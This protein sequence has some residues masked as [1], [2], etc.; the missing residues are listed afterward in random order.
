MV[1]RPGGTRALRRRETGAVCGAHATRLIETTMILVKIIAIVIA[2]AAGLL[3]FGLEYRW[4][5][6][7]TNK[8]KKVKA[9]LI[10]LM[11]VGLLTASIL[12]VWDGQQSEEQIQSAEKAAK[13]SE[14]RELK[15]IEDRE[16]IKVDLD[17]LQTEYNR[18]VL[19]ARTREETATKQRKQLEDQANASAARDATSQAELLALR[20]QIGDLNERLEPLVL[21]ATRIYPGLPEGSA[22]ERLTESLADVR[23][24]TSILDKR[25]HSVSTTVE[26]VLQGD[27]ADGLSPGPEIALHMPRD[28]PYVRF[29]HNSTDRSKDIAC[30]PTS[31]KRQ[32]EGQNHVVVNFE[33]SVQPGDWPL[34]QTVDELRDYQKAEFVVAMVSRRITK[35][36]NFILE[37]ARLKVFINGIPEVSRDERPNLLI[38]LPATGGG[39]FRISE[40]DLL[41]EVSNK[42]R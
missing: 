19:E 5:D 42:A 7:R 8:H 40:V 11:V 31:I 24:R 9:L 18:Q 15:A 10:L 30:Y 12:V 16:S 2:T 35:S 29:V 37:E 38:E 17:A 33:A 13:D 6:K 34:G 32:R 41:T 14:R 1:V 28:Y 22:L 3:R 25:V 26:L 27:W 21:I 36:T 4:H 23:T 39:M 20:N